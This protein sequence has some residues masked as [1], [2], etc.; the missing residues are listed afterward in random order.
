MLW[1]YYPWLIHALALR[2]DW[3][4]VLPTPIVEEG[5]HLTLSQKSA[6]RTHL[7]AINAI[8]K[9]LQEDGTIERWREEF[10]K[11]AAPEAK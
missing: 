8:I 6:Y 10:T 9:R 1:G 2:L 3:C 7:P 5:M 11:M 4:L